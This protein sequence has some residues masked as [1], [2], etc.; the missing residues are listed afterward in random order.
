MAVKPLNVILIIALTGLAIFSFAE[1]RYADDLFSVSIGTPV[2]HDF[3]KTYNKSDGV[4]GGFIHVKLPFQVGFG[5]ER[6]ETKLKD[7]ESW[8]LITTM[9][10]LFYQFDFVVVNAALGI[11]VGKTEFEYPDGGSGDWDDG[12]AYQYYFQVGW[13]FAGFMD[14]HASYH[15]ITSKMDA[16]NGDGTWDVSGYVTA[17][18]ISAGF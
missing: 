18:G 15:T 7:Q 17:I 11:G 9:I 16:K 12:S 14:I 13:P 6:Y 3:Y 1:E 4:S 2:T 5:Y 8:K 10:D